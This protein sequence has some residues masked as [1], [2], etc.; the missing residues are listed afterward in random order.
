LYS[1]QD[2]CYVASIPN[3]LIAVIQ[4]G[5]MLNVFMLSAFMQ[6]VNLMLSVDFMLIVF[7]LSA[8]MQSVNMMSILC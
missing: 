4:I 7:I 2:K 5:F 3:I 6:S 1:V 8:F